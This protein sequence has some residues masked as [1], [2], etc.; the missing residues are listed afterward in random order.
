[1]SEDRYHLDISPNLIKELEKLKK[2][3][4]VLLIA[5]NKKSEEIRVDPHR[6]KNLNYPLNN[7]KRVHIGTHFVLLFSVNEETKTVTLEKIAHHDDAY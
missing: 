6:Y 3:N 2:K 1:M 5:I 4:R 7:L